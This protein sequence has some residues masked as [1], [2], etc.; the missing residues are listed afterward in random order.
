M[1][2]SFT[3]ADGAD[4]SLCQFGDAA[5]TPDMR[6][7]EVWLGH[8]D[9][10]PRIPLV[11]TGRYNMA[12]A[13]NPLQGGPALRQP[14]SPTPNAPF[15]T[16]GATG[17]RIRANGVWIEV[18][19]VMWVLDI[20]AEPWLFAT[21]CFVIFSERAGV[22]HE[23]FPPSLAPGFMGQGRWRIDPASSYVGLSFIRVNT[24]P[25]RYVVGG[26]T[27]TCTVTWLRSFTGRPSDVIE[28]R[29]YRE[30]DIVTLSATDVGI[31]NR[32]PLWW[33]PSAPPPSQLRFYNEHGHRLAAPRV[34]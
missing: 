4:A 20:V 24:P 1:L 30:G 26:V 14:G 23:P 7:Y 11:A 12:T 32:C 18:S 29:T 6:C 19:G 27:T 16:P 21:N 3:Y 28:T 5:L 34:F 33:E 22:F 15:F 25:G 10:D 8:I 31:E 17:C 13:S 9:G 2:T